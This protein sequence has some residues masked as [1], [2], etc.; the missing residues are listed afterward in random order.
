MASPKLTPTQTAI[1]TVLKDNGYY[2]FD[3]NEYASDPDAIEL[4][5]RYN[6]PNSS[7]SVLNFYHYIYT[8]LGKKKIISSPLNISTT[9]QKYAVTHLFGLKHNPTLCE[10]IMHLSY[11]IACNQDDEGNVYF[12]HSLQV[13]VD[14]WV[15]HCKAIDSCFAQYAKDKKEWSGSASDKKKYKQKWKELSLQPILNNSLA[16]VYAAFLTKEYGLNQKTK[17]KVEF[18]LSL[19][20]PNISSS[21]IAKE[22]V[23]SSTLLH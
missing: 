1:N 16:P 10:K 4:H 7:L 3:V 8:M 14:E 11:E 20:L 5:R 18:L 17:A 6:A 22:I 19:Q 2:H 23:Q 21:K 12:D 13:K 9:L 15:A